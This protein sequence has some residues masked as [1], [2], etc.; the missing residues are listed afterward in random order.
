MHTVAYLP[1][2]P[3]AHTALRSQN[4][5]PRFVD[6]SFREEE[7][8]CSG[9]LLCHKIMTSQEMRYMHYRYV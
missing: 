8:V 4:S 9:W 5:M 7:D 6:A 3:A 2:T 1:H